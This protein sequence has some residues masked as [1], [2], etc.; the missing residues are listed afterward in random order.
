MIARFFLFTLFSS[1]VTASEGLL[2]TSVTE[3][4]WFIKNTGAS[5]RNLGYDL[6]WQD[7][8][9]RPGADVGLPNKPIKLK[10]KVRVAV[11]DSGILPGH[12][13]LNGFVQWQ[14]LEKYKTTIAVQAPDRPFQMT[15]ETGHGTH[16]AGVMASIFRS[17]QLQGQRPE[18]FLEIIPMK[19]F[20]FSTDKD[21]LQNKIFE[22]FKAAVLQA[23]E[24]KVDVIL[25]SNV[26]PRL[27][28][29]ESMAEVLEKVA[30]SGAIF[31]AAPGNKLSRNIMFPCDSE[32]S[33]CVGASNQQGRFAEQFSEVRF[34]GSN[35]GLAVDALAPGV[36]I[37]SSYTPDSEATSVFSIDNKFPMVKLDGTSQ[38]API[39]AAIATILKSAYP[40]ESRESITSRLYLGS[41][42]EYVN[43]NFDGLSTSLF[44]AVSLRKS[45]DVKPQALVL[46]QFKNRLEFV[47]SGAK[48]E[49]PVLL[50]CINGPC[51][52]A[53]Y[54][55]KL[56]QL[57]HEKQVNF[58]GPLVFQGG[59]QIELKFSF[60]LD[61]ESSAEIEAEVYIQSP[62]FKR[63][64]RTT[65]LAQRSE[66]LA[67]IQ[68][69]D[70]I[71]LE[72]MSTP[73]K[74][75]GSKTLKSIV[76]ELK[77][78]SQ[79][80]TLID[81]Q[82]RTQ[83]SLEIQGLQ[84]LRFAFQRDVNHDGK[85]ELVLIYTVKDSQ[86]KDEDKKIKEYIAYY[87]LN[88]Q[89]MTEFKDPIRVEMP[90][91]LWPFDPSLVKWRS[92]TNEVK[93]DG[94]KVEIPVLFGF[95]PQTSRASQWTLHPKS[96]LD[97]LAV[98]LPKKQVM[99]FAFQEDGSLKM[100]TLTSYD[101]YTSIY[102]QLGLNPNDDF[103][104]VE[105]LRADEKDRRYLV[106]ART[107]E[108]VKNYILQADPNFENWTLQ[109][110]PFETHF[111]SRLR[112]QF[113]RPEVAESDRTFILQEFNKYQFAGVFQQGPHLFEF[114]ITDSEPLKFFLDAAIVKDNLYVITA[115]DFLLKSWR[116]S[117]G[118]KKAQ[119]V[120]Q[121]HY[122]FMN[123]HENNSQMLTHNF[124]RPLANGGRE[125]MMQNAYWNGNRL[126]SLRL[127]SQGML[128]Y[129][130]SESYRIPT[131]CLASKEMSQD[132][133][134]DKLV[135][136]LL[137]MDQPNTQLLLERRP[138]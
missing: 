135:A 38:S 114:G 16:I 13:Y 46:P 98:S 32:F 33:F 58:S 121:I 5:Y 87:D 53:S 116:I 55:V 124:V 24:L 66:Q 136:I 118:S 123:Y 51:N 128:Y 125:V 39:V 1:L 26:W 43:S 102:K 50:K 63:A 25:T 131:G 15:D 92:V 19:V 103:N 35:Y 137:C 9:G 77:N 65:I 64:F 28:G 30:Q 117:R 60:N 17:L 99:S 52:G 133:H 97:S 37:V 119:L 85:D 22:N 130:A 62:Q 105:V 73:V 138:F 82:N 12:P 88:L 81:Y 2:P 115:N 84:R 101:F 106:V 27:K 108:E 94:K 68:A 75:L 3:Q 7:L 78:D 10:K 42:T 11:V 21:Y 113:W 76:A 89:P 4:M 20:S 47:F 59:S 112:T 111:S 6:R 23:L 56:R 126:V 49:I 44:G 74:V 57:G 93:K 71:R 132:L 122:D 34:G 54:Q 41:D 91:S 109:Q 86:E 79:K 69:L 120:S 127:N 100:Q 29:H 14:N 8:Q 129:H 110:A 90:G 48:A 31:V 40:E 72:Q 95:L 96:F 70:Y 104:F 36:S 67:S 107:Q 45:L 61:L 134:S 83:Q 18:D 80:I